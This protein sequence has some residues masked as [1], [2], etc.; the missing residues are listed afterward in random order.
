[1]HSSMSRFVSSRRSLLQGAA[2]LVLGAFVPVRFAFARD[3]V[4]AVA[5]VTGTVAGEGDNGGARALAKAD[6]VYA[7]EKVTTSANS[8]VGLKLEHGVGLRLGAQGNVAV[9]SIAADGSGKIVLGGGPLLIDRAGK[10]GSGAKSSPLTIET[11]HCVITLGGDTRL[12]AGPSKDVFGVFVDRG[13]VTVAGGG[14]RVRLKQ[15]EGTDLRRIGD[16]ATPPAKWKPERIRL[17]LE[18]VQA[19]AA[20]EKPADKK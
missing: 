1:M 9:A 2:A 14:R 16:K 4:G 6:P 11:P 7:N 18:S 3:K 10:R 19:P 20:D 15:G 5:D 12:F 17:A 8:I 13:S